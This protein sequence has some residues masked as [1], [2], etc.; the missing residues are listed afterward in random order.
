[1]HGK[2]GGQLPEQATLHKVTM[3]LIIHGHV[4]C[5]SIIMGIIMCIAQAANINVDWLIL[6]IGAL[7]WPDPTSHAASAQWSLCS[8]RL[9]TLPHA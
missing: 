2:S 7:P 8:A 4:P 3:I 6:I 9:G 5:R 1:M